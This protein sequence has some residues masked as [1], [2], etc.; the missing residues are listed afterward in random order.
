M[1]E[2]YPRITAQYIVGKRVQLIK[3]WQGSSTSVGKESF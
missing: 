1:R 3:A 2:D